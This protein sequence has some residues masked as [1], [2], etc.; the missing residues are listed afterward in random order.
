MYMLGFLLVLG[1]TLLMCLAV[2]IIEWIIAKVGV[3]VFAFILIVMST[4]FL[5]V[6]GGKDNDNE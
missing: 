4:L 1:C 3:M 5:I 2:I 6:V